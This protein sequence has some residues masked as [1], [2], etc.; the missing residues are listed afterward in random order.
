MGS[1]E[2]RSNSPRVFLGLSEV[3]GYLTRLNAGFRQNGVRSTFISLNSHPFEYSLKEDYPRFLRLYR[4]LA[5]REESPRTMVRMG[6]KATRLVLKGLLFTWALLAFDVFVFGSF[7]SFFGFREL[8]VL[9]AFNK[10]II[11]V[12]FGTDSRPTYLSGNA[13]RESGVL[14]GGNIADMRWCLEDVTRKKRWM[15]R[16]ER[17]ADVCIN[18]PASAHFHEKPFVLWQAVGYPIDA[19]NQSAPARPPGKCPTIL[20]AP[21]KPESKGSEIIKGIVARLQKKG[22]KVQLVEIIGRPNAEVLAALQDCDLVM[23]E[24]YSDT[25]LGAL[26]V[27]AAFF[28]KATVNGGYYSEQM[29][30][31]HAAAL[32]P[33]AW[34]CLPELLEEVL[35][36]ALT[37][38]KGRAELGARAQAFV[39]TNWAPGEVARRYLRLI[40]GDFPETWTFDPAALSYL[41]G[42]GLDADSVKTVVGEYIHRFGIDA[43]HLADKPDLERKFRDLGAAHRA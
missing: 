8:P 13:L 32:I 26:G 17:Y 20:H 28:G 35:E 24:V 42:Y 39:R 19:P 9:K 27:E 16:V 3:A 23:D 33:P 31:D 11:F 41:Y 1:T 30:S 22:H 36:E 34:Y 12:F 25:A 5:S 7:G 10:K 29:S 18:H 15:R 21:S 4:G 14:A 40:A 2:A 6:A 37:N 43:L 38:P